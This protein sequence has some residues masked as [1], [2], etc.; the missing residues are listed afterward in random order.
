MSS[1]RSPR[2]VP[3]ITSIL[4][5]L[6]DRSHGR[7]VLRILLCGADDAGDPGVLV[8]IPD[9][10]SLRYVV[11]GTELVERADPDTLVITAADIFKGP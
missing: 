7:G 10:G 6:L 5:A 1:R 4:R 9:P 11:C 3:D 2:T 8:H